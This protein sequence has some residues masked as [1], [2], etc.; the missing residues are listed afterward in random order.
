MKFYLDTEFIESGRQ[1]PLH[2]VSLGL[3]CED[4]REYYAVNKEAPLDKANAWVQTHVVPNLFTSFRVDEVLKDVAEIRTDILTF[5][6]GDVPEFWGYF[7]DYDWVVF[8][9]IFGTMLDLPKGW[10]MYC[11]DLKQWADLLVGTPSLPT[12]SSVQHNALNDARWNLEV[13][14]FLDAYAHGMRVL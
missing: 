5:V 4:G 14:R 9:Q 2:L 1:E 12:Q 11:R 8:C 10:P 7:A 13:Y 6:N 3:V